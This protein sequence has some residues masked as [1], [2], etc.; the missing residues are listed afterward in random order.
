MRAFADA[1]RL[2][3]DVFL[4][5]ALAPPLRFLARRA[6][7][8]SF[9]SPILR[10]RRAGGKRVDWVAAPMPPAKISIV[11]TVFNGARFVGRAV[12]SVVRQSVRDLELIV[13]DDGSQDA[14][15]AVVR[16]HAGSDPRVRVVAGSHRGVAGALAA[17]HALARG[18]YVGYL[19]HDDWLAPTALAETAA[20]LD[21]SPTVGMVY[22]DYVNVTAAARRLGLGARCAIPYSRERL[23]GDFMTY[24]FRLLRATT[25]RAA[26][27][28]RTRF[29]QC[30]DYDLALRV[31]EITDVAHVARPLYFHRRHRD[32]VSWRQQRE[33]REAAARAI[34][35]ALDRRGLSPAW[36]LEV[37][38][39]GVF[40]LV[41]RRPRRSPSPRSSPGASDPAARVTASG[42]GRSGP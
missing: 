24:H 41:S 2:G 31:S 25:L 28:I 33:Q 16:A 19:D 1:A 3:F 30:A 27:G 20:V 32:S 38:E 6:M 34:G 39:A 36:R 18:T 13:W 5:L 10:C 29:E 42:R 7:G 17:G 12:D 8:A 15:L 9:A 22:T 40:T 35:E 14:S 37:S 11:L 23:L 4:P 26:G 21:A